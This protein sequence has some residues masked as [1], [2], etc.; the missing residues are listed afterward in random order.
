[1]KNNQDWIE[2]AKSINLSGRWKAINNRLIELNSDPKN[3]K[4]WRVQV[5]AG[6]CAQVFVEYK[7]VR[8]VFEREDEYC[9]AIA[10]Y[11]RNLL[12]LYVW[13]KYCT[14]SEENARVF[15]EDE[16]RDSLD[17]VNQIETWGETTKQGADWLAIFPPAKDRL[18]KNADLQGIED[19]DDNYSRIAK[20]AREMGIHLEFGVSNKLLSKYAHPT[21]LLVFMQRK[22][23][24]IKIMRKMFY[25]KACFF[26]LSAFQCLEFH[27]SEIK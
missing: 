10:W 12:E 19:L 14:A 18:K 11:A 15:Y 24:N 23:E 26:F 27:I 3:Y 6:L 1:M 13:A 5:L 16:V 4:D 7:Q 20:I 25:E 22:P 8:K 9:S 17:L 21:A 2:A